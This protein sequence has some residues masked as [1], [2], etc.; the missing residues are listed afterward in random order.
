MVDEY[1]LEGLDF[2]HLKCKPKRECVSLLNK[3]IIGLVLLY[4]WDKKL[5]WMIPVLGVVALFLALIIF[6][7]MKGLSP[8]SY[9]LF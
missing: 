2:C 4:L 7:A 8:F 1:L 5:L 3:R 9:T 6:R